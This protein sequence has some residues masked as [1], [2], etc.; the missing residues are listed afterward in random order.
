MGTFNT[1][2]NQSKQYGGAYPVWFTVSQKERSGGVL[3]TLP[4]I[5]TVLR[6]GTLVSIDTAGG[7]AK[8]IET[9]EVSE[10]VASGDTTVKVQAYGSYPALTEGV[11]LMKAP[12]DVTETGD[13]VAVTGVTLD[14]T[15]GVYEFTITA[16]ALGELEAGDILVK[17]SIA[18]AGATVYA[19]PTGL[20]ENDV[21]IEA[22]DYAATVASVYHGEIMEDRIQPIPEAFK[23]VLP[24]I[25]F[26]KGV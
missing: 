8:V 23:K 5:G 20:T 22:G 3:E 6:A 24:M 11:V 26:Q 25:K 14:E 16:G 13:A 10:A 4:P 12:N 1:Y 9:F 2:G 18:G 19:V 15:N 7:V 17:A 21:Y